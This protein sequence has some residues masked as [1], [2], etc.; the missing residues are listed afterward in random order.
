MVW[1]ADE[2][3]TYA[4]IYGIFGE[5]GLKRSIEWTG[6]RG[7]VRFDESRKIR[8]REEEEREPIL[9]QGDFAS[10]RAGVSGGTARNIRLT[11]GQAKQWSRKEKMSNRRM[12]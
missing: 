9:I 8:E 7:G 3:R 2:N 10:D 6:G 4:S 1:R 5:Y 11:Q 12:R